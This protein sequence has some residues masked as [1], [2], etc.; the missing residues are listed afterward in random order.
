VAAPVTRPSFGPLRPP[1]LPTV[2]EAE[3]GGDLHALFVRRPS[4]PMVEL[5]LV[6][7]LA[8]EDITRPAPLAVL[9]R[10]LLAG[11]DQHDRLGLAQQIELLGGSLDADVH[12]DRLVV[13]GSALAEHLAPLLGLLNEV[14][15]GATYEASEV[16]ADRN[17]A[18]D[19]TIIAL[20]Q[21]AVIAAQ[22]LR[23]RIFA[24][25][26]YATPMPSP[27]ALQRVGAGPLRALHPLV[28]D[29]AQGHLVVAGDLQP[30]RARARAEAALGAWVGG[31]AS[32][33][34]Q[35]PP[36]GPP[37]PGPIELVARPG[38]VQSNV[39]LGGP[40][41][42]PSDPEWAATALADSVFAGMFGS[43][44]VANLRER[45]GYSYTPGSYVRH[46]RAGSTVVVVADVATEATAAALV[47]T[48]YELGRMATTGITDEEREKARRYLVGRFGF[49]ISSLPSF[50]S[51][52]A[53]LAVNGAGLGYLD[54]YPKALIAAT[55][56]Q[57]DEAARHFLAPSRLVTV[58]VGDPDKVLG[59]LSVIGE[60]AVRTP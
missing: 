34:R 54:S 22:A 39:R 50:A 5:R 16:R 43:R 27:S 48:Y 37:A 35:A 53:G 21:P 3:L 17:R 41:P 7:P 2:V 30:A 57:V 13:S 14:L 45:N 47:E 24:G 10:S 52:L 56:D 33:R 29:P 51:M 28:L 8:A 55:K 11:T 20:S 32:S 25:H 6:F 23:Q 4:L 18:A 44:L 38:S 26:P 58:V 15:V 19:E 42:S 60:V 46:R 40:G 1:K 59:P 36:L 49:E 12:D 9:A 31:Q